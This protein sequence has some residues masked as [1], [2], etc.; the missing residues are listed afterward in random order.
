MFSSQLQSA[1]MFTPIVI[2]NKNS[3]ELWNDVNPA[4]FNIIW[5]NTFEKWEKN[6]P[7]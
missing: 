3:R 1:N 4:R 5:L 6:N 7:S 2:P